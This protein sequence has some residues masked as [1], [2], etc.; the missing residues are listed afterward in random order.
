V[1]VEERGGG[2]GSKRS[3]EHV[4]IV[5]DI[6]IAEKLIDL[7][8]DRGLGQVAGAPLKAACR[9]SA[10]GRSQSV[11]QMESGDLRNA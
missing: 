3:P 10:K 4:V 7:G 9:E 5:L 8:G 1:S 6:V 11:H 2:R